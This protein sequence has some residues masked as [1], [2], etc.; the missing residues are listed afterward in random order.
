MTLVTSEDVYLV[1][2]AKSV[3]ARKIISRYK[4][5]SYLQLYAT[6]GSIATILPVHTRLYLV[7]RKAPLFH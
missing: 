6:Q 1:A 5:F 7:A 4:F 3:L 2:L